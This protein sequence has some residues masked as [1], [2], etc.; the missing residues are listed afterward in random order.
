MGPLH[1]TIVGGTGFV[2]RHLTERLLHD[3]HRLTLVARRAS[4]AGAKTRRGVTYLPGD[5]L[6]PGSLRRAMQDADAAINLVGAVSQPS[7]RA[8]FDLHERGARH[9]AEAAALAGVVRLIH[10]SALGVSE[11]APSAADRSKAA[12]ERAVRAAFPQAMILRPSLMFGEDDHFLGRIAA[13]SRHSPLVPLIGAGTRVQP[14][15]VDDLAEGVARILGHPGDAAPLYQVA[16]PEVH[17]LEG[18]VR[19]LLRALGRRRLLLPLPYALALP[20]GGLLG[21]L[22]SPPINREQV[23]LMMTDKAAVPGLPGL[24]D[25]GVHPRSLREWLRMPQSR[26]G[27]PAPG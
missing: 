22:P 8:Y 1:V 12:G 18:L 19:D 25:L 14:A 21:L 17:T 6:E 11:D 4:E 23:A 7:A 27:G 9:V 16:G 26:Y 15:H 2:G 5:V 3:G 24:E 13:M 20:L 10:I